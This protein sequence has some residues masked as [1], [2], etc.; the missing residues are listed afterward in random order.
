LYRPNLVQEPNIVWIGKRQAN[1]DLYSAQHF[2]S[3]LTSR[4]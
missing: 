3:V 1:W 4:S 2:Y